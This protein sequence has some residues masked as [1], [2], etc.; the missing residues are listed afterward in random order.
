MIGRAEIFLMVVRE[1]GC[2]CEVWKTSELLG[3]KVVGGQAGWL[4]EGCGKSESHYKE[5]YLKRDEKS[6][7]I[8]DHFFVYKVSFEFN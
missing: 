3:G 8:G 2:R 7:G 6:F 4:N 1:V 5:D